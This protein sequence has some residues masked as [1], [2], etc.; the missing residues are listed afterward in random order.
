MGGDVRRGWRWTLGVLLVLVG[1]SVAAGR[2]GETGPA[3][4]GV[5]ALLF[6]PGEAVERAGGEVA[7]DV[8]RR[9]RSFLS[10]TGPDSL[11]LVE[12]EAGAVVRSR[13]EGRLPRGVTD[14]RLDLRGPTAALSAT[15]RFRELRIGG[16]APSRLSR[17]LGDSA[18]VELEVDPS[19]AGPGSGRVALTGLRAGGL[20][21]PGQLIPF[22]LSR[23]G[24][25][26]EG[27]DEPAVRVPLPRAITSVRIAADTLVVHRAGGP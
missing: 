20:E 18:R 3:G 8:E 11:V 17:F 22:M 13:L 14:L 27:G 24:V 4:L 12:E 7:E 25:Q 9:L 15:V 6:P 16:E 1:V 2:G 21:L 19:V 10:G 26:T 23:L 5:P